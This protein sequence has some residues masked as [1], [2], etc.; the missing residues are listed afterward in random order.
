MEAVSL[1]TRTKTS[2]KKKK[3]QS[4]HKASLCSHKQRRGCLFP[5]LKVVFLVLLINVFIAYF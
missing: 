2:G 4:S 5:F 1:A 3:T